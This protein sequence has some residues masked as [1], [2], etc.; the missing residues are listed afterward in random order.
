MNDVNRHG[1]P[2]AL[3]DVQ[4]FE[5]PGLDVFANHMPGH[6]APTKATEQIVEAGREIGKA[7]DTGTVNS[8]LEILG[9][10]RAIRHD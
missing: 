1:Q 2:F 4:L 5:V 10:G 6:V 9:E 7:P 3:A 8:A